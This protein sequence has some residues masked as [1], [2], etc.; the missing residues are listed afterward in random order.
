MSCLLQSALLQPALEEPAVH[1][2]PSPVRALTA[3][4]SRTHAG[5]L[6]WGTTSVLWNTT[7]TSGP[8]LCTV[9]PPAAP[10][11]PSSRTQPGRPTAQPPTA[12]TSRP[13]PGLPGLPTRTRKSGAVPP[14]ES[15]YRRAAQGPGAGAG[16]ARSAAAPRLRTPL[17][18]RARPCASSAQAQAPEARRPPGRWQSNENSRFF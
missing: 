5:K 3:S 8:V 6:T 12:Q 13:P 7:R 4:G 17:P 15:T 16:R 10:P 18:R 14:L 2:F 9:Y 1:S 11:G